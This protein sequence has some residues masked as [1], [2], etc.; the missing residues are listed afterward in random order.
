MKL[1]WPTFDDS[2]KLSLDYNDRHN[3]LD[4]DLVK[5]QLIEERYN[6]VKNRPIGKEKIPRIIH[7]IWIGDNMPDKDKKMT[8]QVQTNMGEGWRYHLWTEK[9]IKERLPEFKNYEQYNL[10]PNPGQ[11]SDLLRAQILHEY[12]GVYLDTDFIMVKPFNELL[13]LEFFCGVSFDN[14]P[15]L[16]NGLMA[17]TPKCELITRMLDLDM[18]IGYKDGMDVI[19]TTGP[20]FLT[21]K[22]FDIFEVQ[23]DIVVMPSSFFYPFPNTDINKSPDYR[24]YLKPE[25]ICCHMWSGSWM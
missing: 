2:M 10:T 23:K 3:K 5:W 20:W 7:Q 13:D 25:T 6:E 14:T 8:E 17:C 19:T 21:R 16:L 11:K 24:I 15:T 4:T 12:G 9:D 22:L 18:P 1:N